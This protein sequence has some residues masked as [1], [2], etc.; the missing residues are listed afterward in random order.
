[1]SIEHCSQ[2]EFYKRFVHH[3]H[4][5]RMNKV[6][7]LTTLMMIAEIAGGL[8]LGS[9]ALLA[10]GFHMATHTIALGISSF[11][12]AYARRYAH[13]P[14]YGFG[15]GKVNDLAGY[16][17]AILLLFVTFY[18]LYE[19]V[20]RLINPVP[21][22]YHQAIWIALI[23]LVV[24]IVSAFLLHSSEDQDGHSHHHEEFAGDHHHDAH[25]GH[26]NNF[27]SAYMHVI[28]DMVTSLAA[29]FAL[30]CGAWLGWGWMD[31]VM[32]LI[33]AGVILSW[34]WTLLRDTSMVLLDRD[35]DLEPSQEI[36]RVLVDNGAI[37]SD[38]HVW[39]V[40]HGC[41]AAVL[42]VSSSQNITAEQV[43]AWLQPIQLAHLTVEILPSPAT[44]CA[45][46]V[47]SCHPL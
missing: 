46:I 15:T 33:G 1:M 12:Y 41:H 24:N 43:R 40:G 38:M 19:S 23:G 35:R 26:D 32:G 11:A 18:V 13:D 8:F 20:A 5:Q 17:S 22:I 25:F 30:S 6:V 7:I 3:D 28:A 42:T 10:D 29:V 9:M 16:T 44:R 4:E 14:L 37:I 31:P 45:I 36:R 2:P 27:R 39:R 34:A 21:I 47:D